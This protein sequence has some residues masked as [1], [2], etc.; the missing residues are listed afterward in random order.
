MESGFRLRLLVIEMIELTEARRLAV[1]QLAR[2]ASLAEVVL[3]AGAATILIAGSGHTRRDLGVA[4][5]LPAEQPRLSIGL[6]EIG[7][8]ATVPPSYDLVHW[9]EP[10]KRPDPCQ[11]FHSTTPKAG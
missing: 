10:I 4:V 8:T 3:S 7:H 2:D 5:W 11:V 9:L 1:A 6:L